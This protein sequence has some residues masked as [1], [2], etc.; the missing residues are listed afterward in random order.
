MSEW[1]SVED[2][3]PGEQ[4]CDSATVLVF[5][6]G[7]CELLDAECR[8]GKGWGWQLGFYDAD[9][10]CFYVHGRPEYAVTHW[11]ALPTKPLIVKTSE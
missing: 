9:R 3:L 2:K 11:Q 8:Q 4:G 10:G 7:H 6:M 1:I 5:L